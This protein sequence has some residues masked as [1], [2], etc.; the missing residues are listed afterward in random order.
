MNMKKTKEIVA[1]VMLA[2]VSVCP[3]MAGGIIT[4]TNQNVAF[5][6]NPARDGAIEVWHS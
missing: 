2:L 1:I 3:A 5:L 4:N 6:R